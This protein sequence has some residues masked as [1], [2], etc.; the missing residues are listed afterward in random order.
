MVSDKEVFTKMR[1]MN[2]EY[3]R[4]LDDVELLILHKQV[5]NECIKRGI[6]TIVDG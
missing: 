3:I 1:Q 5:A 6:R 4:K 2:Q